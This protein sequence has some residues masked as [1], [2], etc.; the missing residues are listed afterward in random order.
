MRNVS[1]RTILAGA[2]AAVPAALPAIASVDTDAGLIA[3]VDQALA[4]DKEWI[5]A[6][7]VEEAA[8]REFD[9]LRPDLPKVLRWSPE[10]AGYFGHMMVG[11]KFYCDPE[12]VLE[13]R[14]HTT[15]RYMHP[16]SRE[17]CDL[18]I[19]EYEKYWAIEDR[20]YEE[21]GLIAAADKAARLHRERNTLIDEIVAT[22][23]TTPAGHKAKARLIHKICLGDFN[24]EV[25]GIDNAIIASLIADLVGVAAPSA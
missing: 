6:L 1:R 22:P 11:G 18:V 15:V 25:C 24:N 14:D 21:T 9:Q 5:K 19:A 12:T 20:L 13:F 7:D 3:L 8:Q 23:A 4:K 10:D 17:R 2:A 16:A